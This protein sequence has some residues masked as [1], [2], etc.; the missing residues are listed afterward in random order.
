ML[1]PSPPLVDPNPGLLAAAIPGMGDI[2]NLG[3][4][5]EQTSDRNALA[6]LRSKAI[7]R[8]F[9]ESQNLLPILFADEWDSDRQVWRDTDVENQPTLNDALEYFEREVRFISRNE[10]TGFV[11]VNIEWTDP[12]L[13]AGWANGLVDLTDRAIRERDI[14][15]ARQG[16]LFLEERAQN[17]PLESVKQLMYDLI[18]SY[19]KKVMVANVKDSYVF[20]V[21]D[22]A[23]VPEAD[24]TINMPLSLKFA[25][26]L[27][28]AIGCGLLWAIV[29]SRLS[30]E[31]S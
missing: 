2:G 22:P 7:S 20:T 9:I 21:I 31:A 29:A 4:F 15:E 5:Q 10:S 27:V 11:R 25:L 30:V 12:E 8:Q 24:N 3:V 26:A 28:F 6:V 18:E 14:A 19:A 17:A 16:I 1:A 13:A 23:V